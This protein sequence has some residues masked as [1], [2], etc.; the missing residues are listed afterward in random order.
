MAMVRVTPLPVQVH[1][2]WFDGRPRTVT[3]ADATLPVVSIA[4]VRREAAAYPSA[5]GPRTLVEVVTPGARLALSFRHR[6]RRWL[7]EGIDRPA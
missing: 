3:F 7:I 4:R 2:D 1:C 6:E 5:T